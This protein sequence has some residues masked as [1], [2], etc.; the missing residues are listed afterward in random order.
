MEYRQIAN[1]ALQ[2]PHVIILAGAGWMCVLRGQKLELVEAAVRHG[3]TG[4]GAA[5]VSI[6]SSTRI[7]PV[8]NRGWFGADRGGSRT[9]PALASAEPL[10]SPAA[11]R[12]T[13]LAHPRAPSSSGKRG[14]EMRAVR[15]QAPR[16]RRSC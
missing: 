7:E 5:T 9:L 6:L 3:A 13:G 15:N 8:S 1:L 12:R 16:G 14:M 10:L 4:D 11:P 2:T